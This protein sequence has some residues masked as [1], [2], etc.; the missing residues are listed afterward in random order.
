MFWFLIFVFS[1]IIFWQY[2]N[3]KEKRKNEKEKERLLSSPEIKEKKDR[4]EKFIQS[5][6]QSKKN[7][8]V[9]ALKK[10]IKRLIEIYS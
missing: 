4:A 10:T 6:N 2:L 3:E 8:S 7:I 5:I 9:I 1:L